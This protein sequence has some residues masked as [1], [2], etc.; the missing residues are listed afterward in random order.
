M[1]HRASYVSHIRAYKYSNTRPT[2][3][4]GALL[5]SLTIVFLNEINGEKKK[6]VIIPMAKHVRR[7]YVIIMYLS[8]RKRFGLQ[9]NFV[10]TGGKSFT[11]LFEFSSGLLFF[12]CWRRISGQRVETS[13]GSAGVRYGTSPRAEI[14]PRRPVYIYVPSRIKMSLVAQQEIS[15]AYTHVGI[16]SL[17]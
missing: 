12:L 3:I 6:T 13:V 9:R 11:T 16:I 10:G 15:N 14:M 7:M 1:S 5:F 17:L 4:S 2:K 8:I